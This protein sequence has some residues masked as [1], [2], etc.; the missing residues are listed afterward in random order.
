MDLTFIMHYYPQQVFFVV[1]ADD[2]SISYYDVTPTNG[3]V[4]FSDGQSFTTLE[5]QILPDSSPEH[6]ETFTVTLTGATGGTT[7]N[8]D[9]SSAMFTIRSTWPSHLAL[10]HCVHVPVAVIRLTD[11]SDELSS[12]LFSNSIWP[13][14]PVES[15]FITSLLACCI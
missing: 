1:T 4:S 11:Y 3:S 12:S 5:I 9:I 13:A 15:M 14:W 7:I 10:R 2:M 6:D 8:P